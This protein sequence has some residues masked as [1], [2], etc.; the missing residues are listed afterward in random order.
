MILLCHSV[1]KSIGMG[2]HNQFL[3]IGYNQIIQITKYFCGCLSTMYSVSLVLLKIIPVSCTI[4]V[5]SI[6]IFFLL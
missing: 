4:Q 5:P 2:V 1:V 3:Q 6:I